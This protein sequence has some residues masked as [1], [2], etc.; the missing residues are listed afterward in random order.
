MKNKS[1]QICVLMNCSTILTDVKSPVIVRHVHTSDL[2]FTIC[3]SNPNVGRYGRSN[4]IHL[5]YYKRVTPLTD[6]YVKCLTEG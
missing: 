1:I 4:D 5:R 3:T 6:C 2:R